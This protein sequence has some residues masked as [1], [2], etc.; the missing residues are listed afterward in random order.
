LARLL[1]FARVLQDVTTFG[2]LL[3]A[4]RA[5]V[6]ATTGYAHAWLMVKDETH[7]TRL[8]L[9][10]TSSSR[11][12]DI[13]ET[14]PVL[15][16]KGDRFIE[17]IIDSRV[18]VVVPDARLDPRTN[19][20]IVA[21]LE[22]R[23]LINIPLLLVDA[24]FGIFGVG[25]FGDEGPRAPTEEQIGYLVG[26]ASQISV[27]A[28]RLRWLEAKDRADRERSALERRLAQ[29]QKLESLGLLAG[30]IAHDFNNLL[31][32]IIASAALADEISDEDA[33]RSEI[34]QVL[35][36]AE[37]ASSLTRQLLAVSRS[38][39]L[40]LQPLDLNEV[41]RQLLTLLR[42]ILPETVQVELVEGDALPFVEG[43][44]SQLEQVFMNLLI[45]A[46]DAMPEGGRV[47]IETEQVLVNDL[48][49]E[50]HPMAKPG[51]YVLITVTDTGVGMERETLEH[52]F[53]P[54][55]TT[56]ATKAGTGLGL[57]V[58]Y[59]IVR[60][61]E[62]MLHCD[63]EVGV[64]TAF[65]VYFPA[66]LRLAPTTGTKPLGEL[67]G[68]NARVLVAEDEAAVRAVVVRILERGGYDVE[69]VDNGN[70]A[71]MAVAHD[72]FDLVLMD[73]V[74]PGLS[75]RDAVK[76]IRSVAPDA[77][78]LLTSGYTAGES[79]KRLIEQTGIEILRKPYDPDQLLRAVRT[80][81]DGRPP[82]GPTSYTESSPHGA[83]R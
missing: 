69:A 38:Q 35:E 17:E 41:L 31:T 30:G 44:R 82:S 25:T 45:N 66:A 54:F 33:V 76:H 61:H 81:I 20:D 3:D 70:A 4:S 7:P 53:E 55:F 57:A 39:G 24:P 77:R 52:I 68:G 8:R 16:S 9:L 47:R 36:A 67:A 79:I 29:V 13:W 51:N 56:K 23:T 26:M 2:D 43:D 21:R 34:R 22:N 65:K 46:R 63:S 11:R 6:E 75:C 48:H 42:R 40:S 72:A 28:S 10:E 18:P 50:A 78:I 73:V 12:A 64:G 80:A 1:A 32:V 49:T 15:D 19:K 71:C 62:G 58:S 27:A 59:G 37:R 74:M 14:A 83:A 5:E 60:Q